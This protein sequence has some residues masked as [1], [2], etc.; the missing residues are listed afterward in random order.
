MPPRITQMEER[1]K[2][3]LRNQRNGVELRCDATGDPQPE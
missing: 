2:V 1:E 3:Y